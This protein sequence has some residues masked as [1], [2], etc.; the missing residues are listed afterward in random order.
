MV[1]RETYLYSFSLDNLVILIQGPR[2]PI[3]VWHF[4]KE[5]DRESQRWK[6]Y[7]IWAIYYERR[8]FEEWDCQSE[9]GIENG[10]CF[11]QIAF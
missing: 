7:M 4:E 5:L 8:V 11:Q 3:F 10:E 9:F 1:S 2:F 6:K